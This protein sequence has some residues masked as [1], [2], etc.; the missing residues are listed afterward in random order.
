MSCF[1]V[2]F[3]NFTGQCLNL[4][5]YVYISLVEHSLL[6]VDVVICVFQLVQTKNIVL[7]V[8]QTLE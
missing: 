1:I 8:I 4:C 2:F 3:I 6:V 7:L 5:C